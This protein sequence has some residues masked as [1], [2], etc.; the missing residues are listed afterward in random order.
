LNQ[1]PSIR[2]VRF[3]FRSPRG[4][5]RI[6]EGLEGNCDLGKCLFGHHE[7]AASLHWLS[8]ECSALLPEPEPRSVPAKSGSV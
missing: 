6:A 3:K 2:Q 8:P 7:I 5:V 4:K 1:S